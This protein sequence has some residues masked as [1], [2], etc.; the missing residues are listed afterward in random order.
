RTASAKPPPPRPLLPGETMNACA[1]TLLLAG[2]LLTLAGCPDPDPPPWTDAGTEDPW[3]GHD[4]PDGCV[5]WSIGEALDG[6]LLRPVDGGMALLLPDGGST[7]VDGVSA[8]PLFACFTAEARVSAMAQIFP[9]EPLPPE[10]FLGCGPT[11]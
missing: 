2:V 10:A 7:F 8:A 5:T 3:A 11:T 9:R 1:R 6:G 4:I